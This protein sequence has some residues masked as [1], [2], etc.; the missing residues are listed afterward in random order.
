MARAR[1]IKPGVM[2]NEEL[3]ELDPIARLLFIYLWMLA[4]REGRLE[5]R[6][7]KIKAKAL[8]YDNADAD[9]ILCALHENGFIVRY[10]LAGTKYIQIANFSKHQKP[11]SNE[12]ASEIPAWSKE[13]STKVQ[14]SSDH[15]DDDG[16]ST[17][18]SLGPCISDSLIAGLSDC[19]LSLGAQQSGEALPVDDSAALQ[20]AESE[21]SKGAQASLLPEDQ[22]APTV[23]TKAKPSAGEEE[24]EFAWSIYPKKPGMHSK[25]DALKQWR[26]RLNQ[27][28]QASEMIAG[29]K[30][31]AAHCEAKGNTGGEFVMHAS[32][33]FGA[34]LQFEMSWD[35]PTATARPQG[36]GFTTTQERNRAISEANMRA[37]LEDDDVTPFGAFDALPTPNDPMTIDME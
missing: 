1:N 27:G 36:G 12:T 18:E 16:E 34:S 5:D 4:D 24:F 8:P 11:H 13:L 30:R 19:S 25:Q 14:S 17:S 21:S 10:E 26:A 22:A 3:A 31:Y 7:K 6:P 2:E 15:G 32:R 35:I 28:K 20:A 37:F 29:V 9:E 33:F 23:T